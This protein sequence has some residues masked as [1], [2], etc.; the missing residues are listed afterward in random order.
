M[1]LLDYYD[2]FGVYLGVEKRDVVHQKG[3]W[4]KTIHCWL[5][6]KE[7]NIFFQ[8]RADKKTLYTT[9]SGHLKAGESIE[10][11]F[12]R[13][14]KEEIGIDIDSSDAKFISMVPFKMNQVKAD[15]SIFKDRAFANVYLDL[16]E[17]DY[18]DFSMDKEEVL[19]LGIVNAEEVLE[20]FQK[21]EGSVK[22]KII[23]LD[24]TVEDKEF[25]ISSFLVN[26]GE[27]LL[28]KYGDVLKSVIN[29]SKENK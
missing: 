22:G 10:E 19:G 7:G 29:I 25:T 5:Y 21:N 20:L 9:A 16:Y 27:T 4:H 15:G 14:I 12:K 8:I 11:G 1:E 2:E 26:E 28:N 17:G 24:N 23:H 13:E 3:L 6:D 18:K